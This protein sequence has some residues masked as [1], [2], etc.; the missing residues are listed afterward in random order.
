MSV[1]MEHFRQESKHRLTLAPEYKRSLYLRRKRE[2]Y[3]GAKAGADSL[4][5]TACDFG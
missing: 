1:V 2:F 5:A 4:G 3:M